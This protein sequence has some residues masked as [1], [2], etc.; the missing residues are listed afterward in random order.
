LRYAI[1]AADEAAATLAFDSAARFYRMA[2]ELQP[3]D[4]DIELATRRKLGDALSNAGLAPKQQRALRLF[5]WSVASAPFGSL[6][7]RGYSA[8]L[9]CS[10]LAH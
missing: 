5:F 3:A 7:R 9:L 4:G 1:V 10:F 8:V 2:L 6:Q